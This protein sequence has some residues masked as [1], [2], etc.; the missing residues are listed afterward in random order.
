M[1]LGP[2]SKKND[3]GEVEGAVWFPH[4]VIGYPGP[5]RFAVVEGTEE[6]PFV[7]LVTEEHGGLRFP[8]IDPLL[9]R[10][11]Y[12]VSL[13]AEEIDEMEIESRADLALYVIVTLPEDGGE[14]T[15]D[16]R[17]PIAVS[18]ANRVGMQI[19]LPESALPV[20]A[21]LAEEVEREEAEAVL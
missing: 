7:L 5:C 20:A 17:A 10:P 14:A 18:R 3:N 6:N 16:L 9:I 19:L 1:P 21:P 8:M 13:S 12:G 15:V 2:D 11:D 4:G